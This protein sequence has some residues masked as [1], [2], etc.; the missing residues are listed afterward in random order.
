[1][2]KD[3]AEFLKES[4]KWIESWLN[5]PVKAKYIQNPLMIP[6]IM[7]NILN[8][9]PLRYCKEVCK[10]WDREIDFALYDLHR[11]Q[12]LLVKKYWD[13]ASECKKVSN[14]LNAYYDKFGGTNP[15]YTNA[16]HKKFMDLCDKK[17]EIFSDQVKIEERIL[18]TGLANED[19][20]K[21]INRHIMCLADGL[22]PVEVGW[23][24]TNEIVYHWDE[25]NPLD[26]WG[27]EDPD[28]S[29]EDSDV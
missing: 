28:A 14:E 1:M 2:Y 21:K 12:K 11:K 10:L 26:Y 7:A 18:S 3:I 16:L 20:V 4:S 6:E 15:S 25:E 19:E 27:D 13:L 17:R 23:T 5:T 29:D 8:Y 24:E 9:I 22:D